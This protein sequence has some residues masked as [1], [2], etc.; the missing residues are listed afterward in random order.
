MQGGIPQMG[1]PLLA[2]AHRIRGGV[3]VWLAQEGRDS[4]H[5]QPTS[6]LRAKGQGQDSAR[7]QPSGHSILACTG[8]GEI[9]N[10]S[11][12]LKNSISALVC[13]KGAEERG[14]Q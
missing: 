10:A 11:S 8:Q 5:G 1:S 6:C 2:C 4:V 14:A 3:N 12:I 13:A 7:K 9:K